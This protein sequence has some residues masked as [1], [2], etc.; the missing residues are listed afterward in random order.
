MRQQMLFGFPIKKDT[1]TRLTELEKLSEEYSNRI[2]LLEKMAVYKTNK[3][4]EIHECIYNISE[5]LDNL[6]C[7]MDEFDISGENDSV[8]YSIQA[9][10]EYIIKMLEK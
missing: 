4:E 9:K 8:M 7:R 6:E 1:K 10:L 2:N 5:R 3:I